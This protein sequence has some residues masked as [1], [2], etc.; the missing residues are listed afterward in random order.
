MPAHGRGWRGRS[1]FQKGRNAS[2]TGP[3]RTFRDLWRPTAPPSPAAEAEQLRSDGGP[4]H[5][6]ALSAWGGREPATAS[7]GGH[8]KSRHTDGSGYADV[9]LP[10]PCT[11]RQ[12]NVTAGA[13]SC[14]A[15]ATGAG[16]CPE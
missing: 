1:P 12:I 6:V 13:P 7:S 10:G 14:S 2:A 8:P 5:H 16:K 9:Y 4:G 3:L 15:P 11:G